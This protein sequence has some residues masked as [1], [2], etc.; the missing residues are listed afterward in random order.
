MRILTLIHLYPPHHVGGYEVACRG[1]MERFSRQGHDVVVLT[2]NVRLPGTDERSS[3]SRAEVRRELNL[4]FDAERFAPLGP[5]L[6]RRLAMERH[7]QRALRRVLAEF[8]PEVASVWSMG[9]SSWSLMRILEERHVPLVLTLLDDW[10]VYAHVFDPW[11][12]IFDRRRWARPLGAAMGGALGMCTRLPT[13]D[14]A[15]ASVASRMIAD[16]IAA[17]GRWKFPAAPV[18]PLGVDTDE[19]PIRPPLARPWGWKLVYVGRVVAAKG[20]P[21]LIRALAHLPAEA[22]LDVIGHGGESELSEMQEL[23][24]SVGAGGRVRFSRAARHEIADRIGAADALVF[25]SE[26]PEPFG[27]VPLEA[28]ACG[29]P[30]V[31]TGTGGSGE[32]LEDEANC[33]LF[34]P[35]DPADL[36][37]AL[38]R[39]AGDSALR[40][41]LARGGTKTASELNM[42][43]YAQ[44]LEKLHAQAAQVSPSYR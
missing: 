18:I 23:A 19:V 38:R 13:M 31:A 37:A 15:R 32:F 17:Y 9:F 35:G 25:P 22:T 7:N 14:G 33:L 21:T 16:Q 39:L 43:R 3:P 11:T 12:R 29:V 2:S 20:V 28:M 5:P 40:R 10:P 30:V 41:R 36:A 44:E 1:T 26:W 8:R 34:A 27:I 42:D 6:G 4:W 24:T